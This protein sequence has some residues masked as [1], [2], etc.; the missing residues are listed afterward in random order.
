[1]AVFRE[2]LKSLGEKSKLEISYVH[3]NYYK[4]LN[5]DELF[6]AIKEVAGEDVDF[7]NMEPDDLP[8]SMTFD[9]GM[10]FYRKMYD[11]YYEHKLEYSKFRKFNDMLVGV[12]VNGLLKEKSLDELADEWFKDYGTMNGWGWKTSFKY[13]VAR[14]LH[15]IHRN[16]HPDE[17]ENVPQ[18][19]N[20]RGWHEDLCSCGFGSSS[21]SSD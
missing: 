18:R 2:Y 6:S 9:E 15:E 3:P 16:K 17:H 8:E 1:M 21:D 13:E 7:N 4:I 20:W 10:K 19:N 11:A 5:E 14:K 12:I